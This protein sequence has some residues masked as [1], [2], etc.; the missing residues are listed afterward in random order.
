MI[1]FLN[2]VYDAR[3][4]KTRFTA[5]MIREFSSTVIWTSRGQ[6]I[7]FEAT[8]MRTGLAAR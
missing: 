4:D 6:F 8:L 3:K 2:W 1:T 5:S 7:T